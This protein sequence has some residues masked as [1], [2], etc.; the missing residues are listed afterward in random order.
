MPPLLVFKA[1]CPIP[2]PPVS[3]TWLANQATYD[4]YPYSQ[5][6]GTGG[7]SILAVGVSSEAV[8]YGGC[9]ERQEAPTDSP[10]A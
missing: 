3:V 1:A 5:S 2:R 4:V 7:I 9:Q 10:H 8:A 6:S